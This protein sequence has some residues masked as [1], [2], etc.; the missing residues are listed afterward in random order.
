MPI[1]NPCAFLDQPEGLA[2][3]MPHAQRLIELRRI[4]AVA[5]P[6]PLACRCSIANI[7]Q[8]KIIL[9]AA[10]GAVAAKLRLLSPTLL[11]HFSK[12]AIEVTGLEVRVQPPESQP[13]VSDKSTQ[14]SEA[15]ATRLAELCQQLPDSEL[16]SVIARLADRYRT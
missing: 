5:L 8:G 15:G 3:L 7:R 9:F 16:K 10:N 1:K 13:Y 4:L 2:P 11:E 12:R 6:E 14:I